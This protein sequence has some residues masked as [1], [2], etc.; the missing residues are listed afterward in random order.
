MHLSDAGGK[1]IKS[2]AKN[3]H[4]EKLSQEQEAAAGQKG[5]FSR[6]NDDEKK[7]KVLDAHI[8]TE[9][10]FTGAQKLPKHFM[11]SVKAMLFPSSAQSQSQSTSPSTSASLLLL[12]P[13]LFFVFSVLLVA[14]SFCVV[15]FSFRSPCRRGCFRYF[16]VTNTLLTALR[17]SSSDVAAAA[18]AAISFHSIY[19]IFH[20]QT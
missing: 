8:F 5:N 20:I 13:F 12:S 15:A 3:M 11:V 2:V 7:G 9:M 6:K 10:T 18:A 19:T 14:V 16:P 17:L 1:A 4:R